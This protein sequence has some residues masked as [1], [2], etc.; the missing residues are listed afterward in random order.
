MGI[1]EASAFAVRSMYHWT[2]Q[3]NPGQL[4]F[5]QDMILSINNIV[6]WKYIC[7][8]KQAQIEKAVIRENSTRIDHDYNIGDKIMVKRN[9]AYKY[10][11]PFQGPYEII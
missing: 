4:C 3:T 10:E 1:L 5:G 8:Q 6:N 2:K 9:W 7:Q 11:T